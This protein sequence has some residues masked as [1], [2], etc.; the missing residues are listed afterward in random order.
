MDDRWTTFC[1]LQI[2]IER[3]LADPKAANEQNGES[4]IGDQ[5]IRNTLSKAAIGKN[6]QADG[7]CL[8]VTI[9]K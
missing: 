2:R 4:P 1:F 9:K 5:H 8:Q 3:D 7:S 6:L